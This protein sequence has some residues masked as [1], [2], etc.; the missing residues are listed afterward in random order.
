MAYR[1]VAIPMTLS[2]LQGHALKECLL[3]AIFRTFVVLT[4]FQLP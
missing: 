2:D 1:I 4:R 3:N